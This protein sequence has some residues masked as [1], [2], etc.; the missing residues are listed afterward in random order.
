MVMY[1]GWAKTYEECLVLMQSGK[2]KT[3]SAN[4]NLCVGPM[5]GV[6]TPSMPLWCVKNTAFGNTSFSRPADLHQQF[7]NYRNIDAIRK[8]TDT[9]AV[10]RRGLKAMGPIDLMPLMQTALDMGDELHNRV[11]AY[12]NLLVDELTFGMLDAGVNK[13]D[14]KRALSFCLRDPNGVR[15][16]LGLAMA[17]GH[18]IL[19]PTK[20]IDYCTLVT[21]M[22]RNGVNWGIRLSA[23]GPAWYQAPAPT[24]HK[25]Y[26]FPPY[27]RADFG[28]D[29]GDSVITETAG[30]GALI[31]PNSMALA[32]V[33]G[34]T[35]AEA[36][37]V[38]AENAK[39]CAVAHGPAALKIAAFGMERAPVGID[40][41]KVM[42]EGKPVVINTG[43]AH[44][45]A[46]HSVVARGLLNTPMSCFAQAA[47][48]FCK[49]Y[50]IS[51]QDFIAS[52]GG[53]IAYSDSTVIG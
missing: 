1:E 52:T 8:W 48:A 20:G 44:K 53:S 14:M 31:A 16:A 49:K 39:L 2:V 12:T 30:W 3:G 46:G 21:C 27:T 43:I 13:D 47:E 24:C 25:Y 7:G 45:D 37:A 42:R 19:E 4:E 23:T 51:M 35:P 9:A 10:L 18:A 17:C 33:V 15:L 22:S 34:A 29:M 5:S 50:G 28:N 32:Y 41:R 40:V 11:N 6:I 38:A 26:I 36:F